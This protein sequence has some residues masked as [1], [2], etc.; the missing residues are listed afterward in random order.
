MSYG[1]ISM[2]RLFNKNGVFANEQETCLILKALT[3]QTY[4]LV[5]SRFDFYFQRVIKRYNGFGEKTL[6]LI[7]SQY[8]IG[9]TDKHHFHHNFTDLRNCPVE[10]ITQKQLN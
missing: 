3:K 2:S 5:T 6:E 4:M 1:C 8:H 10:T 7:Q 9:L